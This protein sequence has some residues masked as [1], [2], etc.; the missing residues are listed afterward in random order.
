MQAPDL[1][2]I[3][4]SQVGCPHSEQVFWVKV[5]QMLQKLGRMTLMAIS[6]ARGA[7]TTYDA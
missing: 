5:P 3:C 2:S 4:F 6:F 1:G 7:F